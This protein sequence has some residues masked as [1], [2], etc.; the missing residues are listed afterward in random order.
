MHKTRYD[1]KSAYRLDAHVGV[2][3]AQEMM[4]FTANMPI[5]WCAY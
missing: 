2:Q 3:D 1:F 4:L 5:K